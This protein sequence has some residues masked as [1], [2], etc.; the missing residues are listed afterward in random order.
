MKLAFWDVASLKE[1]WPEGNVHLSHN[2]GASLPHPV[3]QLP[4]FVAA[5]AAAGAE[6]SGES[7]LGKIGRGGVGGVARF[8]PLNPLVTNN[9]VAVYDVVTGEYL[10]LFPFADP[11][12]GA[13][14]YDVSIIGGS[15]KS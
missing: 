9:R 1:K 10:H 15:W 5:D 13:S 14:R 3:D 8:L 6:G 2:P 7:A 11:P 12:L 4:L